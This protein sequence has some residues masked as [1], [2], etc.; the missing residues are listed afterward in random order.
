VKKIPLLVIAGPTASGKSALALECAKKLGGELIS[1][2]SMQIYKG[3][4]VGTAKPTKEEQ[5]E[6][7]HYLVDLIDIHE[8][9]SS[10]DFKDAA[11][12]AAK[13][14]Y[15]RGK[16]PILVGG[17][18]LYVEL[19]VNDFSLPEISSSETLREELYGIAKEKGN[20]Y[21]HSMLGE[22]DPESAKAIHYNNVKRVVRAIEVYRGTGVTMSEWNRR[23]KM[24]ESEFLPFCVYLD[25]PREKLYSRINE[26]VD[27]FVDDG[28]IEEAR[29][30]FE[31]GLETT[32]TAS[33]AIGY[34][35][36]FPYLRGESELKDCLE[37][38]KQSTRN[39]AKRQVTYFTRMKFDKMIAPDE[40]NVD[41]LFE[42]LN[43][44]EKFLEFIRN[45]N[46]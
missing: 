43:G 15:S 12:K 41:E 5:A 37:D 20:E 36:L 18:G 23:S 25:W 34:K 42:E 13:E 33:Q 9:Y 45:F 21:L 29:A 1:G 30:L 24:S 40:K 27:A 39:L 3:M 17:S 32:P 2:D 4:D 10:G 7:K 8:S 44:D 22:I 26:R 14:I 31:N 19:V 11:K 38:L 6:V 46:K 16:L 35:E 28:L